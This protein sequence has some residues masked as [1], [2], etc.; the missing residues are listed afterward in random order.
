MGSA[1]V[2]NAPG[3]SQHV[4]DLAEGGAG[5][6]CVDDRLHQWRLRLPCRGLDRTERP[7]D[8]SR[9]PF[10]TQLREALSLRRSQFGVIGRG[11]W[12]ARFTSHILVYPDHHLFPF[13]YRALLLV[14]TARDGF[15]EVATFDGFNRTSTV[16][17]LL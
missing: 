8:V 12:R 14:G 13:L 11:D 7:F 6:H 3:V 15:L 9:I 2:V 4:A 10:P 16:L 5:A 17:H 1:R